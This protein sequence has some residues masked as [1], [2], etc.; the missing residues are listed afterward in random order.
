MSLPV[1]VR[2]HADRLYVYSLRSALIGERLFHPSYA[3]QQDPD[4]ERKLM[5]DP[6]MRHLIDHRSR[7]VAGREW[8]IIA[9]DEDDKASQR[10]ADIVRA[11]FEEIR[12]FTEARQSLSRSGIFW[13]RGFRFIESE[14]RHLDL[15]KTGARKWRLPINLKHID[16]RR[17][18]YQ[19]DWGEKDGEPHVRIKTKLW[20]VHFVTAQ[21]PK[22]L[23]EADAAALIRTKFGDEEDRLGYGDGL[24]DPLY[25]CLYAKWQLLQEGLRSAETWARGLPIAKVDAEASGRKEKSSAQIAQDFLDLFDKLA[26]RYGV[27]IDS[28]DEIDVKWPT[29]SGWN[30]L[31][32][33]LE[34]FKKEATQLVLSSELPTGGGEA[35]AGS[36]SRSQVELDSMNA[37][38]QGDRDV[39]DESLTDSLVPWFNAQNWRELTAIGVTKARPPKFVT[40]DEQVRD[41]K[42]GA[43]ILRAAIESGMDVVTAEGYD[44]LGLTPP[45][46]AG[47]VIEGRVPVEAGTGGGFPF[48]G[49]GPGGIDLGSPDRDEEVE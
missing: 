17:I 18:E 21:Q 30:L 13:G 22:E 40:G 29:G 31:L 6:H 39:V 35:G 48:G 28:R 8:R 25:F 1:Q 12:Q 2:S 34:F 5:R 47:P 44:L 24:M 20:P 15:A 26:S 9:G 32:G 49:N 38:V 36:L 42:E 4:I 11:A 43:E 23:T 27:A 33:L 45:D 10:W 7:L 41:P 37:L 3:L 19:P 16:H 14:R 46:G